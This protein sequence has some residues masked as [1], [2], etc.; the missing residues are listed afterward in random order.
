MWSAGTYCP[1]EGLIGKEAKK[2]WEKN[3]ELRPDFEEYKIVLANENKK[4]I[5]ERKRLQKIAQYKRSRDKKIEDKNRSLFIK[6]CKK[7]RT[8]K[9]YKKSKNLCLKEYEATT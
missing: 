4:A 2:A 3:P 7:E 8:E 9:G 5:K 1:F 6:Q